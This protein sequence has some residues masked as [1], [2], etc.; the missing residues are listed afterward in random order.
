MPNQ[1]ILGCLDEQQAEK[2]IENG[3]CRLQGGQ[4]CL[5]H[6]LDR[7]EF[8]YVCTR[9][10]GQE[11]CSAIDV[12][13][14]VEFRRLNE[15][16][17]VSRKKSQQ[18]SE[19]PSP[20]GLPSST[21]FGRIRCRLTD[22]LRKLEPLLPSE[23]SSLLRSWLLNDVTLQ[24]VK[25]RYQNLRR[26]RKHKHRDLR[27]SGT[28]IEIEVCK[29]ALL[30]AVCHLASRRQ[31]GRI[32]RKIRP[33][34][35]CPSRL[36]VN[37]FRRF[38]KPAQVEKPLF[39]HVQRFRHHKFVRLAASSSVVLRVREFLHNPS[40]ETIYAYGS[41]QRYRNAVYSVCWAIWDSSLELWKIGRRYASTL[42]EANRE[43]RAFLARVIRDRIWEVLDPTYAKS[44]KLILQWTYP[45][46][47]N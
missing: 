9:C 26:S 35:T 2:A 37:F 33:G 8:V 20:L 36:A 43:P 32:R 41:E 19:N 39:K 4:G 25:S 45:K 47:F 29:E 15:S 11:I 31:L 6:V 3:D 5:A 18:L 1:T 40:K 16:M 7:S 14:Q 38:Q 22:L 17:C 46:W 10:D 34:S 30:A 12:Q 44:V 21:L 13:P 28:E 24:F 23:S 42:R 27:S